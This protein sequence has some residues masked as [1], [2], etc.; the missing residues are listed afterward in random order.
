MEIKV[1]KFD[2]SRDDAPYW[3]EGDVPFEENMSALQALIEFHENVEPVS[4]DMSC[5]GSS[6]GRCAMTI[7]GVPNL[8]CITR[9]DDG[10]HTFEP[11]IGYPVIRDL[12]VDKTLNTKRIADIQQRVHLEP[13]TEKDMIPE[14]YS[15]EN[16]VM[17]DDLEHCIRCGICNSVCPVFTASPDEYVGPAAMIATAF[18]HLD[19]YDTSDRLTEAV[20]NGLYKCILCGNCENTCRITELHHLDVWSKLRKDAEAAGLKPSYA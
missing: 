14:G 18:R 12:V 20:S 15:A 11:L 5:A 17:I 6:C 9:I 1:L 13:F 2:P 4:F 10:P 7:D 19:P 8:A 16:N 3:V